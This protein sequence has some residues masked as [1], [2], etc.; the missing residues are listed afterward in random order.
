MMSVAGT[1][2]QG[3]KDGGCWWRDRDRIPMEGNRGDAVPPHT[4]TYTVGGSMPAHLQVL[5][6]LIYEAAADALHVCEVHAQ[7][8][9]PVLRVQA[10]EGHRG[11]VPAGG[12]GGRHTA[13]ASDCISV[14]MQVG[15]F[16]TYACKYCFIMPYAAGNATF[17][18][19]HSPHMHTCCLTD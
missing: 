15:A 7:Q 10:V 2:G 5:P 11:A 4:H 14:H 18:I 1:R 3:S 16:H 17:S 13:R 9:P 19:T 8:L 12:G 6:L